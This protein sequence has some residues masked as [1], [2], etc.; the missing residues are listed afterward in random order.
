MDRLIASNTVPVGSGDVAPATG[1][2]GQA[3]DGNPATNTPATRFP[4]YAFNALQEEIIA[5]ILAGGLAL[6]RNNNGQLAAAI[7]LIALGQV[8]GVVGT[9]R[10][11][12]MYISAASSSS[13]F[14]ADEVILETALGGSRYCL[15][16]V[17]DTFNLTTD[18]DTGAA[19]A[20]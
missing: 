1:T 11:A 9:S 5:A 8:S 12:K 17:S 2:P 10:N 4:A 14:T 13:T 18:M 16:N 7:K 19:P 20:S 15:A 6:D 3:T